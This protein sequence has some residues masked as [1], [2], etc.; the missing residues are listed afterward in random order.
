MS[1]EREREAWLRAEMERVLRRLAA[2]AATQ[3]DYIASLGPG[4]NVDEL[5]LE[6]EDLL[7]A[8]LAL[9]VAA[10][11]G[12]ALEAL[13]SRLEAMSGAQNEQLWLRE[14]LFAAAE[15]SEVRYLADKALRALG[16]VAHA[17][18]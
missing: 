15:W 7:S 1:S 4:E 18:L 12:A 5:A 16:W 13:D 10:E 8:F 14:A 17:P 6:L 9:G 11:G 2:P 3:S